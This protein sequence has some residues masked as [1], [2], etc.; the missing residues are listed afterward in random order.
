MRALEAKKAQ[1]EI[2]AVQLSAV[3]LA[4][5]QVSRKRAACSCRNRRVL[6]IPSLKHDVIQIV[7]WP[8][9]SFFHSFVG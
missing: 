6:F 1:L 7:A 3:E 9:S 5:V 8:D 4:V 2:A